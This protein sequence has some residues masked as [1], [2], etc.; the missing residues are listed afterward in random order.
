MLSPDIGARLS[1]WLP[2]RV[3]FDVTPALGDLPTESSLMT[4]R[5]PSDRVAFAVVTSIFFMWGFITVLNDVLIPHLKALFTLNYAQAMLIQFIFFGAYFVMSLPAGR[6]IARIGYRGGIVIGL[7]VTG[8]GALLFVPAARLLSYET[9]L[10]AF[11]VLASGIT[12]LQVAANPYASLL[13]DP[14]YASSRLTLAQALNSLGTMLAPL[15]GGSLIL[16]GVVLGA[17]RLAALVPAE[18]ASYRAQQS[19]LVTG[20]YLAI[21]ATLIALAVAVRL[22]RLPPVRQAEGEN[23][24][25]EHGFRSVLRLPHVRYG[26]IAI[27]LYVGAEVSIGSF[28]INYLSLPSIGNL[29]EREAAHYVSLY[30]GG[31]MLGRF[32]GVFL[33]RRFDPRRVLAC[34]AAIAALLVLTT[35]LTESRV[36]LFSI[37]A[38]GLFNSIM[39]PTIFTLGIERLGALTD[40]A[41]SLLIM[42]IVGGAIVPL[43]E[44]VLA[45]R[46]G[47]QHAF[48]LP[49]VCYLFVVF[50]GLRGSLIRDPIPMAAAPTLRKRALGH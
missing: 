9:F 8:L 36:A 25:K 50:Y 28:M 31:A 16:G 15:F 45:D 19:D 40:K 42:A 23:E 6:V 17:D 43:L 1:A 32:A 30:W 21:A 37:I 3:R 12:L 11:F 41:A 26:V 22:L 4:P 35:M 24:N 47:V 39:F 27:F 34:A 13:G 7:L 44:G 10:G 14:R 46:V 49:F 33:M 29:S 48:V 38:V 20:P 18:L 5:T 2:K